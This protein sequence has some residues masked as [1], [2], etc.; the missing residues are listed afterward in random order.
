MPTLHL[1]TSGDRQDH[2]SACGR[3]A[4]TDTGTGFALNGTTC[5]RGIQDIQCRAKVEIVALQQLSTVDTIY[6]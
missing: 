1:Y 4:Y 2:R 3:G 6:C 5:D